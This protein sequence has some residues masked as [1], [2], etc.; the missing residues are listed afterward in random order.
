V[1]RLA[2]VPRVLNTWTGLGFTFSRAPLAR[3]RLMRIYRRERPFLV[4][5]FTGAR[6]G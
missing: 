1:A 2:R 5:H 3:A 4:H 6:F